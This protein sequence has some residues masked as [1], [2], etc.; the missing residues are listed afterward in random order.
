MEKTMLMLRKGIQQIK[1]EGRAGL[2]LE[3]Q[4]RTAKNALQAELLSALAKGAKT[5]EELIDL[6]CKSKLP[7]ER[8]D[9]AL[10]VAEFILDFGEY[11]QSK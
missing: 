4:C 6:V 8:A 5:P 1:L 10:A 11:L 7:E 3:G 2:A 9:G